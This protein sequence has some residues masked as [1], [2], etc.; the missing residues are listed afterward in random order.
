MERSF[1][2]ENLSELQL[3]YA[4]LFA[5]DPSATARSRL[6]RKCR[7]NFLCILALDDLSAGV[8]AFPPRSV[9]LVTGSRPQADALWRERLRGIPYVQIPDFS[10][11]KLLDQCIRRQEHLNSEVSHCIGVPKP[12]VAN[13]NL[14]N[15]WCNNSA[16]AGSFGNSAL[17]VASSISATLSSTAA[18][19]PRGEL[20]VVN[21]MVLAVQDMAHF[22]CPKY[23][24]PLRCDEPL[25]VYTIVPTTF[26]DPVSYAPVQLMPPLCDD[27]SNPAF[28]VNDCRPLVTYKEERVPNLP[29]PRLLIRNPLRCQALRRYEPVIRK[30]DSLIKGAQELSESYSDRESI[31]AFAVHAFSQILHSNIRQ[32]RDILDMLGVLIAEARSGSSQLDVR[33]GD[34]NTAREVVDRDGYD[35]PE[36]DLPG[37]VG[38]DA[39]LASG[40]WIM[41]FDEMP[42]VM[43]TR[44]RR[45]R[46][47][48]SMDP[49]LGAVQ[50][51]LEW[52]RAS[53]PATPEDDV[54]VVRRPG[55]D[56]LEP[57]VYAIPRNGRK[58]TTY[59]TLELLADYITGAIQRRQA[60][61][62]A[63]ERGDAALVNPYGVPYNYR[64]SEPL[65]RDDEQE[66][67]P[68]TNNRE[69]YNTCA[70]AEDRSKGK[71]GICSVIY[72]SY[73]DHIRTQLHRSRY[74]EQ[75]LQLD[76]YDPLRRICS[77]SQAKVSAEAQLTNLALAIGSSEQR[78]YRD[79]ADAMNSVLRGLRSPVF[80]DPADEPRCDS[81]TCRTEAF[82]NWKSH[83]T[84]K[85]QNDIEDSMRRL[86]HRLEGEESD[87]DEEGFRGRCEVLALAAASSSVLQDGC[88]VYQTL[89]QRLSGVP[90]LARAA[91]KEGLEPRLRLR[92]D[93]AAR[94][95]V[96]LV[97]RPFLGLP[98]VV[99]DHVL[100]RR[101][102]PPPRPVVPRAESSH[103]PSA[104]Q[105]MDLRRRSRDSR[106]MRTDFSA[107]AELISAHPPP[108]S[109]SIVKPRDFS[110]P[111]FGAEE[112]LIY[113]DSVREGLARCYGFCESQDS[114]LSE[115]VASL[116][117]GRP[118]QPAAAAS[119]A[120]PE[121][122]GQVLPY[123][124]VDLC[125]RLRREVAAFELEE[126]GV[127][128]SSLCQKKREGAS[129]RN[130][131]ATDQE[132]TGGSR[133]ES[134]SG[135]SDRVHGR[136]R[137]DRGLPLAGLYPSLN[138]L[139]DRHQI[140]GKPQAFLGKFLGFEFAEGPLVLP[141][142]YELAPKT[143]AGID[144]CLA[145]LSLLSGGR[146]AKVGAEV[147]A[148][149]RAEGASGAALDPRPAVFSR[150]S[151]GL[152]SRPVEDCYS[153][154][155]SLRD[156]GRD[157]LEAVDSYCEG[158]P[159]VFAPASKLAE[160]AFEPASP[161]FWD[162]FQLSTHP[163]AARPRANSIPGPVELGPD[164]ISLLQLGEEEGDGDS[165]LAAD[166][167]RPV[168]QGVAEGMR[169]NLEMISTKPSPDQ[170]LLVFTPAQR[171]SS[172]YAKY[173]ELSYTEVSGR[174]ELSSRGIYRLT[175]RSSLSSTQRPPVPT[176]ARLLDGDSY[177]EEVVFEID[178]GGVPYPLLRDLQDPVVL[179]VGAALSTTYA[180]SSRVL[181]ALTMTHESLYNSL[182]A[183][184]Q[185]SRSISPL[186]S[187]VVY[188]STVAALS[189]RREAETH[190]S[191]V[192]KP[193]QSKLLGKYV[194]P[195]PL[196][197]PDLAVR[198]LA[199]VDYAAR[200]AFG[201]CEHS[202][203][204]LLDLGGDEGDPVSR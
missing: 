151:L 100:Y 51:S 109:K 33:P 95:Q 85:R 39:L 86:L 90:A 198:A 148:E 94:L 189:E 46:L 126:A 62:A 93:I 162:D 187:A 130:S 15:G 191:L 45:G 135:F 122:P 116:L 158:R 5:D 52:Y 185:I 114:A 107:L 76:M 4:V 136:K 121:T 10:F 75:L 11:E 102:L 176:R 44:Y 79:I 83:S 110:F 199:S 82:Q 99:P 96:S 113:Q 118:R 63:D 68:A 196:F 30:A 60:S 70:V 163:H 65:S 17:T 123:E 29:L 159:A 22:Y 125:M 131:E 55:G 145:A 197:N 139:M 186:M 108:V 26:L 35:F 38:G 188:S 195:P 156:L 28:Y 154:V 173:S 193:V 58:F 92:E 53:V 61:G 170:K 16:V 48:S 165:V 24:E 168:L 133:P 13:A 164:S 171:D 3:D 184:Y 147:G 34:F 143:A 192:E 47:R 144:D 119:P 71:C 84:H 80:L 179:S 54:I 183:P 106:S 57:E 134:R 172:A 73:A 23:S 56:R 88:L 182:L 67:E 37:L 32:C 178:T 2:P 42:V 166:A 202:V 190:Y 203:S 149:E 14:C 12:L 105:S 18:P 167:V 169:A 72:G 101:L 9:F 40:D 50:P 21:T 175:G 19:G 174:A 89:L 81:P 98:D 74:E 49:G 161:I 8:A 78:G 69:I 142:Q 91:L 141:P 150:A 194:A 128:A 36:L 137:A 127:Y 153:H 117:Q 181:H 7:A 200:D 64:D 41:D 97:S 1:S 180:G 204:S 140:V 104:R 146:D 20:A 124:D 157:F 111:R 201:E 160:E 129:C 103:H 77:E 138:E 115:L 66:E 27:P 155:L 177:F 59:Q 6:A 152:D 112:Y 120:G 31:T 132:A 87:L 43:G 25:N